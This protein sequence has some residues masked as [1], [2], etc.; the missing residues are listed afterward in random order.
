MPE[1]TVRAGDVIFSAYRLVS[2]GPQRESPPTGT[3][4]AADCSEAVPAGWEGA[5]LTGI[6]HRPA[7]RRSPR[8]R[9]EATL[10]AEDDLAVGDA[11]LLEHGLVAV[12][13]G[14]V[15]DAA[16]VDGMQPDLLVSADL[17][18]RMALRPG[19][20]PAFRRLAVARTRRRGAA[21]SMP[22]G[23]CRS[24]RGNLWGGSHAAAD[25]ARQVRWLRSR[26]L[27]ANLA[28]MVCLSAMTGV[29]G[30]DAPRMFRV[31]G[32]SLGRAGAPPH[33]G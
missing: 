29:R 3:R 9:I 22:S 24:S 5:T 8:E 18:S 4:W 32:E 20:L 23:R 27:N 10:R 11:L 7:D 16:S 31:A 25:H 26:R 28:E 2:G 14:F 1:G 33:S 13:A 6:A 12:V 30:N 19:D 21:G 15:L 17:A